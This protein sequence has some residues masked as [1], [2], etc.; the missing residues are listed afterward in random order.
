M[1]L[2]FPLDI[3]LYV[4]SFLSIRDLRSL[5]LVSRG[6]R[7][8]VNDNEQTIYHQA[9]ILHRFALSETSLEDIKSKESRRGPW[10]GGVESWKEFCAFSDPDLRDP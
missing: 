9:A 7:S 4:L 6:A 3:S 5:Q 8:L 2:T 10:L 1:L